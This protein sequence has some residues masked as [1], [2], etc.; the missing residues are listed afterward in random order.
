MY[1]WYN[2]NNDHM[3]RVYE[4]ICPSS[5]SSI[6][7]GK[8]PAMVMLGG[9]DGVVVVVSRSELCREREVWW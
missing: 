7:V 8:S 5:S 4:C 3:R 6:L 1:K 9:V 2:V